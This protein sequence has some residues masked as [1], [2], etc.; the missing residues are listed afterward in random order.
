MVDYIKRS[1]SGE[2]HMYKYLFV[3]LLS[4]CLCGTADAQNA[5]TGEKAAA[6]NY[7]KINSDLDALSKKLY[8]GKVSAKET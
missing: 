3:L 8:S 5:G 1:F 4:F 6:L 7:T 2:L